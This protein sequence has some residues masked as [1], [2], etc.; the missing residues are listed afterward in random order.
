[1]IAACTACAFAAAATYSS[2]ATFPP[3][4]RSFAE[5]QT[6]MYVPQGPDVAVFTET[7][8]PV[9]TFAHSTGA[10]YLDMDD[11]GDVFILTFFHGPAKIDRYAIGGKKPTATYTLQCPACN[12]GGFDVSQQGE[13]VFF[14]YPRAGSAA[15]DVWDPGKSGTPSR[16]IVYPSVQGSIDLDNTGALYVPYRDASSGTLHYDVIPAGASKPSRTI[17]DTLV[18]PS[19]TAGFYPYAVTALADGTLYVGEWSV[20]AGDPLA[21]L[22]VYPIVGKQRFISKGA[23]N[24]NVISVDASGKVYVLNDS[25]AMSPNPP[26][27]QCDTTHMLSVYSRSAAALLSEATSGFVNGFSLTVNA[28]GE[29][30]I[31]EDWYRPSQQCTLPQ[32][33]GAIATVGPKAKTA[34]TILSG[35]YYGTV[36]LYDGAHATNPGT[37]VEK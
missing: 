30:F 12:T 23:P 9:M 6:L 19:E 34:R 2:P 27:Y 29:S 36:T 37:Q 11:A 7:G 26:F 13:V 15:I 3:G 25:L 28:T 18:P 1:M 20:E 32:G 17:V 16:T 8:E 4:L 31:S 24:P 35:T 21:G 5:A 22:Y 33:F 14:Y 10:Q